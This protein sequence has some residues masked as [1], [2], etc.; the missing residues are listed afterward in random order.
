MNTKK[1]YSLRQVIINPGADP[2]IDPDSHGSK[3]ENKGINNLCESS[4]APSWTLCS[5]RECGKEHPEMQ[6]LYYYSY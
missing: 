1:P 6:T 3:S 5:K 4:V 2:V